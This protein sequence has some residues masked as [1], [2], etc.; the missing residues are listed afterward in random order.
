MPSLSK[1]FLII[2]FFALSL[3]GCAKQPP[4]PSPEEQMRL[5]ANDLA[6]Q[7]ESRGVQIIKAGET[8]ALVFPTDQMFNPLSANFNPRYID[9][10][11]TA[12][13]FIGLFETTL[14]KVS[15]YTNTEPTFRLNQ[16]LSERQAQVVADY[17]F[18][19]GIDARVVYSK[20]YGT[21]FPIAFPT[22]YEGRLKNQRVV[23]FF[24]F[25]PIKWGI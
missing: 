7:L 20:G 13:C 4:P 9:V 12:A 2:I 1:L 25:Q 15:G 14:V 11:D 17:L 19:R 21:Q 8:L 22:T 10:L 16:V 6:Y 23:V 18:D 3:G 24:R 5:F